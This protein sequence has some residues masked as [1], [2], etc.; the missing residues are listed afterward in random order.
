MTSD[1]LQ[2]AESNLE[3]LSKRL[4]VLWE[5]YHAAVELGIPHKSLKETSR[6]IEDVVK[7]INSTNNA[8]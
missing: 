8:L 3:D 2:T 1:S 6:Q 5:E 7:A 4:A